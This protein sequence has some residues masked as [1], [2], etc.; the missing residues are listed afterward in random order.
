MA[1]L[2]V[3]GFGLAFSP[4]SGK[5]AARHGFSSSSCCAMHNITAKAD[6][7]LET[8][9]PAETPKTFSFKADVN[10]K[11]VKISI[12][13]RMA[14][15][16]ILSPESSGKRKNQREEQQENRAEGTVFDEDANFEAIELD[17]AEEKILKMRSGDV[18]GTDRMK[19]TINRGRKS[20]NDDSDNLQPT[21]Q[22]ESSELEEVTEMFIPPGVSL[23][24]EKPL[25]ILPGSNIYIGPYAKDSKVKQAE[26]VKSSI[27]SA[28]CPPLKLPEFAMVGR[29]N[30]G[31]SSLVNLLVQRKDL[32]QTSKK[33]GK[34]QLINHFII[35]KRWYLVDLPGYGYAKAPSSVRA[36]W[37]NFTKDFFLK[38]KSL[39]CV[40]LLIDA[41]ILPQEIDL[42][43][44]DWLHKNKVPMT[45]VFTKCDR[46]KKKKNGGKKPVENI[47]DFLMSLKEKIGRSPPWI[48]TSCISY[49]GK[50]G[51]LMHMAQL[52]NYW[53]S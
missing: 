29:S 7:K 41:S 48:M 36:T 1:S 14:G 28:D 51:L 16:Q 49:Q 27:S 47:K 6:S 45:I 35:N 17:N 24:P 9:R 4:V 43:Y 19:G 42:E 13:P 8:K 2:C 25:P 34:T 44:A 37:D 20:I 33:P 50:D 22:I 32:A 38:S 53:S 31:K 5:V 40:M 21:N 10:G 3:K 12:T 11:E 30:V 39:V 23:S 26:F 15:A 46:K 52:R 18:E